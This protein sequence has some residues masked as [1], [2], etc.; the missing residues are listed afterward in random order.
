MKEKIWTRPNILSFIRLLLVPATAVLIAQGEIMWA[1]A[2]FLVACLTDLLDG[3]LARSNGEVTKLGSVLDPL[4]DKLMAMAVLISFAAAEIL[5]LFVVIVILAK[6]A[7]MLAGGAFLL[8]KKIIIPANKYGKI[9]GF[10]LNISSASGF[11]ARWLYPYYLYAV[12]VA[13]VFVIVAFVQY[14]VLA[15]RAYREQRKPDGEAE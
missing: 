10:L 4:A 5:P 9:A 6:E 8:S 7:C 1:F 3:Y 12:Y 13:L 11:F 15:W 14:A 2:C